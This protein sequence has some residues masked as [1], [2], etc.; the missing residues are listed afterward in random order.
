MKSGEIFWALAPEYAQ[1][2]FE[3]AASV[4]EPGS[5]KC[6]APD[7]AQIASLI[8]RREG[9]VAVIAVSGALGRETMVFRYDGSILLLGQDAILEAL[10][11]ALADLSV[12]AILLSFDSPGGVVAGTKELADFIAQA[13]A[14]KPMGA[15][16]DGLC[17]SAACWLACATGRVFAP[18]TAQVGS[19]GVIMTL[20]DMSG[21][22]RRLGVKIE[23]VASGKYKAA[24]RGEL[25]DAERAYFQ[26][27]LAEI[28][29]IF[30]TDV[31]S[32]MQISAPVSEWA[33]GQILVAQSA[34]KLGLVSRIVRDQAE[35]ITILQEETCPNH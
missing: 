31:A 20:A 30:R 13:R 3:S 9:P 18:A 24:G 5:E 21:Y 8:T 7:I 11:A 26:D 32:A 28:H 33:D 1:Q 4:D 29:A 12:R 25:S 2:F 27:R 6:A 19:I 15:Y 22:F 14:Q 35:A 17:A 10:K 16:C 34:A 23:H